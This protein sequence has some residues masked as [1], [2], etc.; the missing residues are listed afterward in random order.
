MKSFFREL[1]YDLR[2][3]GI[4]LWMIPCAAMLFLSLSYWIQTTLDA[5]GHVNAITLSSMEIII[6]SIGGYG[7]MMLMQGLLDTEGGEIAFTY[8]RT[9]LYW[10]LLRQIRFFLLFTILV[11]V[12]CLAVSHMMRITFFS[13]FPLTL[14]QCFAV[15]GVSF[16]GITLSRQTG[17][18]LI[19]LV[20]FVSIQITLGREFPLFNFIYSLDGTVPTPEA[21]SYIIYRCFIIGGFA[22]GIG[23]IWV[24]PK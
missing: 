9:N 11:A 15:M 18:G 10:G 17:I 5:S 24:H 4:H 12:V 16:L 6:P 22:W 13:V 21:A 1:S 8:R 2:E 20:A 19:V 3:P 23:Q 14:A 7:S